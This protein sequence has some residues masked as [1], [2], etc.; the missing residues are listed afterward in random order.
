MTFKQRINFRI[1]QIIEAINPQWRN[2][3]QD[4]QALKRYIQRG[5]S[6]NWELYGR[7]QRT[8]Y[9]ASGLQAGNLVILGGGYSGLSLNV[10]RVVSVY[11]LEQNKWWPDIDIPSDA[12]ETHQAVAC[13][14]NR[15]LYWIAGQFGPRLHPCTDRCFSLDLESKNWSDLP[16]FPEPMYGPTA[17]YYQGR[18]YVVGGC[19]ADRKT[20]ATSHWSLAVSQGKAMESSWVREADSPLEGTHRGSAIIGDYLYLP[21]GQIGETPPIEGDSTYRYDVHTGTEDVFPM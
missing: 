13:E 16:P 17:Q 10:S 4:K 21:G 9:S 3:L 11:D 7:G 20:T 2:Q 18:I 8:L 15:Y 1:G 14:S 19:H 12:A 6:L 5:G